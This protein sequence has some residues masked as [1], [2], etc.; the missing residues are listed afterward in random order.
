MPLAASNRHHRIATTHRSRSCNQSCKS[1][2]S[3]RS[4]TP[5]PHLQ[6]KSGPCFICDAHAA[7]VAEPEEYAAVVDP[8]G[9]TGVHACALNGYYDTLVE[10]VEEVSEGMSTRAARLR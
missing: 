6:G 2:P 7:V 1:P 10:L 4:P 3:T 9:V 8:D 5:A